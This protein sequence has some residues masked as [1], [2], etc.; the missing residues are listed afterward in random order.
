M[1]EYHEE[2][3]VIIFLAGLNSELASYIRGQILGV[4]TIPPLQ[5]TFSQL[6]RISTATPTAIPNESAMAT[7]TRGRSRGHGHSSFSRQERDT[8]KCKQCG[9]N[10]H[11]LDKYWDKFGRPQW[12]QHVATEIQV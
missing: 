5:S 9:S 2:L 11:M 8:R 12:T 7:S 1:K 3:T 10:N 6:L 4:E